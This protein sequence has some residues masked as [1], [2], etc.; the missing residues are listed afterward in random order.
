MGQ[1]F[2]RGGS[3]PLQC[4]LGDVEQCNGSQTVAPGKVAAN[5][6]H[7]QRGWRVC[8]V[9]L[10]DGD[11]PS[12]VQRDP[13]SGGRGNWD[14]AGSA[15]RQGF[16]LGAARTG[17]RQVVRFGTHCAWPRRLQDAELS[18][19]M[20]LTVPAA[21]PRPSLLWLH[22]HLDISILSWAVLIQ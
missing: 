20:T 21:L 6:R 15:R 1:S 12:V 3:Q 11:Y 4:R 19:P 7:R 2:G 22:A 14:V 8:W 17:L 5:Q 16:R 13:H 18:G 9:R 10:P